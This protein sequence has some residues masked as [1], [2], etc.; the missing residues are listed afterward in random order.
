MLHDRISQHEAGRRLGV[1]RATIARWLKAGALPHLEING[2]KVLTAA[3][4]EEFERRS[5]REAS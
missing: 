1:S 5:K 3:H 2:R 4:L